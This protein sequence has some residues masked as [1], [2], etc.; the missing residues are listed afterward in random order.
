GPVSRL[1][2]NGLLDYY[3]SP[4]GLLYPSGPVPFL[5]AETTPGRIGASLYN[6]IPLA[7]NTVLG[8]LSRIGTWEGQIIGEGRSVLDMVPSLVY[9]T[10]AASVVLP[11]AGEAA[12]ATEEAA[13]GFLGW[14]RRLWNRCPKQS[15]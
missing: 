6:S 3:Y 9:D 10:M 4:G 12:L 13:S 14:L 15:A 5:E 7:A 8:P 1:D 2:A 11:V